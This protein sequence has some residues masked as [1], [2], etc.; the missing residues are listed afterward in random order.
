M[1]GYPNAPGSDMDEDIQIVIPFPL[2]C[3]AGWILGGM[4]GAVQWLYLL[5]LNNKY[6]SRV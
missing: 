6:I 3:G 5:R 1:G 4:A 2:V